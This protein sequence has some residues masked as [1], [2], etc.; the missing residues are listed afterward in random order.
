MGAPKIT[1]LENG[2]CLVIHY[3]PYGRFFGDSRPS[4]DFHV[5]ARGEAPPMID[6]RGLKRK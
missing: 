4:L 6:Q 2:R 5:M 1:S 3:D